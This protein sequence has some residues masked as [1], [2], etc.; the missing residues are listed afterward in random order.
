M[1]LFYFSDLGLVLEEISD[2]VWIS[3]DLGI[4]RTASD[5]FSAHVCGKDGPV[6]SSERY[7]RGFYADKIHVKD[8][9]VV[10]IYRKFNI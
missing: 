7:R 4:E 3:Y 6:N 1:A 8:T 5:Q 2:P 10:P 9:V